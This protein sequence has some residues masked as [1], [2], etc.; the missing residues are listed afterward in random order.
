MLDRPVVAFDIE[1][2]PDPQAGRRMLGLVGSDAEVV[3]EMVKRRLDETKGS[4]SYPQLPLHRVV[5]VCA[6]T[7]EPASGAVSI[8]KLGDA[9]LD[10]RSHV[11]GFFA[12]FRAAP[13]PRIVSWNGGGYDLPVLRYRGMLHG[14]AAPELHREAYHERR[15]DLHVDLM[16]VLSGYGASARVGLA[17]LA[18]AFGL[19]PKGFLEREIWEHVVGGESDIVDEYCKLDTVLTMYLF[20]A[21][22]HHTGHASRADVDRWSQS[23]RA[24]MAAQPWPGWRDLDALAAEWP[25]WPR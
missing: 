11:E 16:D 22:L 24:A 12:L 19:P 6:T 7:L 10:E 8:R 17:T 14:V 2:I 15:G 3:G 13:A 1:T 4:S 25:P 21:W 20:V 9:A 5:T 23:L 18:D